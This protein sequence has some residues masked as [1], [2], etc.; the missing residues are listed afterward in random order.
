MDPDG[1]TSLIEQL[2]AG[3]IRIDASGRIRGLNPAATDLLGRVRDAVLDAPLH[4]TVH[5][6][7]LVLVK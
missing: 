2:P 4:E 1:P 7:Q 3:V 5:A 6:A